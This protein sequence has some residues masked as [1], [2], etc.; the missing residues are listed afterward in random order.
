MA[1]VIRGWGEPVEG[2]WL[3]SFDVDALDGRGV[4]EWTRHIDEAMRFADLGAA[5]E[6]WKRPSK[7]RPLRADGRPNRPL[8]AYNITFDTVD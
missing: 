7:V 1:V 4:E 2:L 3:K 6:A 5:F 8:S